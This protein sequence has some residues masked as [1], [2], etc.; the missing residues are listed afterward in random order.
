MVGLRVRYASGY[1][2]PGGFPASWYYGGSAESAHVNITVVR[3]TQADFTAADVA[4]RTTLRNPNWTRP[5]GYTWNHSGAPDSTRMELVRR[6]SPVVGPGHRNVAH[7]GPAAGPRA[8]ARAV[9]VLNVYL[10][11]REACQAAGVVQPDYTPID[12]DYF[13]TDRDGSVFY[14]RLHDGIWDLWGAVGTPRR[15]FI[16]G[17]RAGQSDTLSPA[18]LVQYRMEAQLRFGLYIPGSLLRPPRFIP[19]TE[20]RTLPIIDSDGWRIGYIDESGPHYYR[21][22]EWRDN[23]VS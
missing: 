20:R 19:G 22:H 7:T 12:A 6:G 23:N 16:T 15:I 9:A 17:P 14:I 3:G 18:N 4:M 8:A 5:G 11:L 2:A 13:F 1:I 21:A 10:T